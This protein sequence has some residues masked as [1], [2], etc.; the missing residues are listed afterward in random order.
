MK[1]IF[2]FALLALCALTLSI[3]PL[4]LAQERNQPATGST[5]TGRIPSGSAIPSRRTTRN[6]NMIPLI[7]RDFEEALRLI[8]ENYV[9]GKKLDYNSAYKSSIIG[10]LRSLDPHSN[11]YDREEYEEL[12]TD[13]PTV[14]QSPRKDENAPDA[15]K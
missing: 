14:D 13:Q 3:Q 6:S 9:E 11:F 2:S 10:M 15:P 12:K 5:S 1:K 4:V 8:E 7:E